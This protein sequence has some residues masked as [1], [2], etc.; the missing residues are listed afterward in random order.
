MNK[1]HTSSTPAITTSRL[2]HAATKQILPNTSKTTL[3]LD[4]DR[5]PVADT[6]S[7]GH[8]SI[9]ISKSIKDKKVRLTNRTRLA[10][11]ICF[12]FR[13]QRVRSLAFH[14][15]YLT[16]PDFKL[17]LLHFD[18]MLVFSQQLSND[19]SICSITYQQKNEETRVR[20]S[21]PCSTLSCISFVKH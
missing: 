4:R 13:Y 20:F 19:V 5:L 9:S 2:L 3:R 18:A 7:N 11:V 17:F 15:I 6:S 16:Y 10:S 12:V 21:I 8:I 14:L 1:P